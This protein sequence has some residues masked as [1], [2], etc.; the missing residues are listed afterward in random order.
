[1]YTVAVITLLLLSVREIIG[2]SNVNN[3]PLDHYVEL[4]QDVCIRCPYIIRSNI[5]WKLSNSHDIVYNDIITVPAKYAMGPTGYTIIIRNIS[6]RDFGTYKCSANSRY[7]DNF[8]PIH[9]Y[10]LERNIYDAPTVASCRIPVSLNSYTVKWTVAPMDTPV[11]DVNLWTPV[12]DYQNIYNSETASRLVLN[13]PINITAS[14]ACRIY[15]GTDNTLRCIQ[16]FDVFWYPNMCIRLSSYCFNNGICSSES[17]LYA[18]CTCT[19]FF[20]GPRCNDLRVVNLVLFMIIPL[21][22]SCICLGISVWCIPTTQICLSNIIMS[23]GVG[24][25]LVVYSYIVIVIYA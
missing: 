19:V 9:V 3:I 5:Y 7:D 21:V 10:E 16:I 14:Y 15:I 2:C 22:A 20:T 6:S 1:M 17:Q 13:S 12:T 25:L 4:H 24:I 18:T 23:I 11:E 8:P